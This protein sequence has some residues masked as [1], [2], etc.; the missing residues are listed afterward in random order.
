MARRLLQLG[1]EA[2]RRAAPAIP[3][4]AP[5]PLEAARAPTWFDGTRIAARGADHEQ[6]ADA[7]AAEL[8]TGSSSPSGA[9]AHALPPAR[10]PG[11]AG[12]PAELRSRWEPHLGLD[13]GAVRIHRDEAAAARASSLG[14]RAFARGSD[15][16]F[17][18]GQYQPRTREGQRLLAHEL[19]HTVQQGAGAAPQ[20][21]M[22]APLPEDAPAARGGFVS[23]APQDAESAAGWKY[24]LEAVAF[25]DSVGLGE[26]FQRLEANLKGANEHVLVQIT[27]G[28]A[29]GFTL[30]RDANREPTLAAGRVRGVIQWN[31]RLGL[32][33]PAGP[34]FTPAEVLRH[35]SG[36]ALH[37]TEGLHKFDLDSRDRPD[38]SERPEETR[39]IAEFDAAGSAIVGRRIGRGDV[40][41]TRTHKEGAFVPVK[42]P[43]SATASS[44]PIEVIER[45]LA[46]ARAELE[47]SSTR[48]RAMIQTRQAEYRI[49]EQRER[50][51]QARKAVERLEAELREARQPQPKGDLDRNLT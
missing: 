25:L 22:C 9:P 31:P 8:V 41:L 44:R 42:G 46:A 15:I 3:T 14:A 16:F 43:T 34:I 39:T 49:G 29:A 24:F 33:L 30:S 38:G 51:T 40:T 47:G 26:V 13:L 36:H 45:Q 35:E 21:A 5:V 1:P 11:G 7:L 28:D 6:Q 37:A 17:G 27:T 18:A 50:E 4:P 48:L 10:E 32:R 2:A 12:L 20:Q 19:A 23:I